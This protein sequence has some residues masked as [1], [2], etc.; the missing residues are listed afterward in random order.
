VAG[1]TFRSPIGAAAGISRSGTG[2][3]QL[4]SAG[5][6]F[7]EV[8]TVTPTRT[9]RSENAEEIT[10][11]GCKRLGQDDSWGIQMVKSNLRVQA[12]YIPIGVNIRPT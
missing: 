12:P 2:L 8:G 9:Y 4:Q 1:I 11:G 5:F 6:G 7:I 3:K 10:E